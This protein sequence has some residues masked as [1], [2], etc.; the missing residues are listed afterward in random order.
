VAFARPKPG[1][2]DNLLLQADKSPNARGAA[3]LGIA[4]GAEALVD[5]A[6]AGKLTALIV[7][8]QDLAE[9]LGEA[10]VKSAAA[11]LELLGFIG[12]NTN[13]TA[14]LAHVTLPAAIYAEKDG[15]FTNFEG[16]VQR[17]HAAFDPA[18]DAQPDWQQIAALGASLGVK[19]AFPDA[20]TVFGELAGSVPAFR[21]MS[22]ASLGDA[23][24]LLAA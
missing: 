2:S 9:L 8:H 15:T 1:K 24:A 20:A 17:I 6:I 3:A 16:R 7:F 12:T 21:G 19:L 11:K 14:A 10:K 13:P 23:G 4:E 22:Y 18:G 5:E